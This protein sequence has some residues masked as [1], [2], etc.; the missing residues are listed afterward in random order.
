MAGRKF[1]STGAEWR[2]WAMN[3]Y[4]PMLVAERYREARIVAFSTGNV[5][6]LVPVLSGGATEETPPAPIGEYAQSCLGRERM[7]Q[8]ASECFGTAMLLVRLNYA[9][10]LRY[11]IL[12]DLA[13]KVLTRQP[14]DLAMG[15]VNAIWQGDANRMVLRAL[16]A[17]TAPPTALNVTGPELLSVRYLA[18]RLGECLGVAPLLRG[19]EADTAL[20]SNA[21]RAFELYGYPQVPLARVI[22]WVADWVRRGG[23]TLSKPT[24]YEQ[25]QGRF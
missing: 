19:E 16:E 20:L 5:Y 21:A 8:Y 15:H 17:T 22:P 13:Q 4:L 1:G 2:T 7:L 6:P 24:H 14:I 25:R 3:A 9:V 10:E 18:R 11:G 12:L 23:A